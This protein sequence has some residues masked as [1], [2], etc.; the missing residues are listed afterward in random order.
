M[1]N[2]LPQFKVVDAAHTSNRTGPRVEVFDSVLKSIDVDK[3]FD[4][5]TV[6]NG[7]NKIVPKYGVNI[8]AINTLYAPKVFRKKRVRN[9]AGEEVLRVFRTA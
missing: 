2:A 3:A 8:K 7:K 1:S 6:T 4:V 9:D 5:P